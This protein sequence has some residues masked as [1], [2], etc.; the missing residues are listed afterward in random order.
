MSVS[1]FPNSPAAYRY[2]S[3]GW[4]FG[5][6]AE[7]Q[8]SSA[9]CGA[10][11]FRSGN[12]LCSPNCIRGEDWAF[13]Y[14]IGSDLSWLPSSNLWPNYYAHPSTPINRIE[15]TNHNNYVDFLSATQQARCYGEDIRMDE[16]SATALNVSESQSP[17]EV[18]EPYIA[19][20]LS[21][22]VSFNARKIH[23]DDP[24]QL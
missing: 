1:Y 6:P 20:L 18:I 24:L 9:T 7:G 2:W 17:Y 5:L 22:H 12:G 8:V 13:L 10:L 4:V 21:G 11:P 14:S 15:A 3:S 16:G 19:G 23:S